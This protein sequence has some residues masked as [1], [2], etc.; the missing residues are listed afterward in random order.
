MQASA[1]PD[2]NMITPA[3]YFAVGLDPVDIEQSQTSILD[4]LNGGDAWDGYSSD[5]E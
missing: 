5:S 2:A 4:L 1:T 3:N